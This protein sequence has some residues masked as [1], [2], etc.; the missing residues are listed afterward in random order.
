MC[1]ISEPGG[2]TRPFTF[3]DYFNDT[4]RWKAYNLHW[5]SG[6]S[7]STSNPVD[8][9]PEPGRCVQITC[10]CSLF[11][12]SAD[13]EYLHKTKDGNVFLHNVETKEES[14]YLSNSTFVIYSAHIF[15]RGYSV[16]PSAD[17][18][19]ILA[20]GPSGCHRLLAVR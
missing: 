11:F 1:D 2:N 7:Q 15:K 6:T 9:I 4:I 8:P 19:F 16:T 14:L 18:C 17:Q 10:F 12:T 3:D 13:K 20:V 5:I